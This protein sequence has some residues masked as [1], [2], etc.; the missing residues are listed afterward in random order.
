MTLKYFK[1]PFKTHFMTLE[2]FKTHF[3]TRFMTLK[4]FKHTFKIRFMMNGN[5]SMQ[6]NLT[7]DAVAA[8]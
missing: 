7:R 2:H 3:K 8:L 4:H 6:M 1:R 5:E